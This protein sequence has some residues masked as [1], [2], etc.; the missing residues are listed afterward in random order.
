MKLIPKTDSR[1]FEQSSY[2][3]YDRH[4][5]RVDFPD[6]RS[7]IFDDYEQ[8]RLVWFEHIRNWNDCTVTVLDKNAPKESRSTKGFGN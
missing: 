1:Y 3:P 4:D 6:G 5:Y 8:L 7:I 2:E